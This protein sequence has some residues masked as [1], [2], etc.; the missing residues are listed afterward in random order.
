MQRKLY[1]TSGP[2]GNYTPAYPRKP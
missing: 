1:N 2:E